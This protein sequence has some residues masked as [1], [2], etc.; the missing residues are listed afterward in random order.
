MIKC[1][2]L[3]AF[4][5]PTPLSLSL[6]LCVLATCGI[7]CCCLHFILCSRLFYIYLYMHTIFLCWFR[8]IHNGKWWSEQLLEASNKS[9]ELFSVNFRYFDSFLRS[10][11]IYRPLHFFSSLLSPSFFAFRNAYRYICMQR[12]RWRPMRNEP[13]S[14][15]VWPNPTSRLTTTDLTK[16]FKIFGLLID[17]FRM[18]LFG[19]INWLYARWMDW[20]HR[21]LILNILFGERG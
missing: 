15:Y 4:V 20:W 7:S 12:R 13:T 1:L 11:S 5:T 10:E 18:K 9:N 6:H 8:V 19:L 16:I 21:K 2:F 14:I 17:R 3:F